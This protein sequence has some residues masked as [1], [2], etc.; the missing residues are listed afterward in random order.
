MTCHAIQ[1]EDMGM[2]KLDEAI[3]V[4]KAGEI[5][6]GRRLLVEVL[7]EEPRNAL[8]WLWMSGVVSD[9]ERR[10]Q[11]LLAVLDIDPDNELAKRGLEAFGWAEEEP[12]VTAEEAAPGDD[13]FLLPADEET[14]AEPTPLPDEPEEL[15][16]LPAQQGDAARRVRFLWLGIALLLVAV[17]VVVIVFVV[18]Q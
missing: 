2:S 4:I 5:E 17:L 18:T 10:R 6:R 9:P 12:A 11:S 13:D 1:E 3:A 14:F 16:P 15:T 7:D 8:A